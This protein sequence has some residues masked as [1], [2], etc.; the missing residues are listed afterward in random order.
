MELE[1][2]T[3]IIDEDKKHILK[4]F[5]EDLKQF[6]DYIIGDAMNYNSLIGHL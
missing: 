6:V 3:E 2:K 4:I 5:K 1:H